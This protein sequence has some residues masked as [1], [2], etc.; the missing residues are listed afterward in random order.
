M[1]EFDITYYLIFLRESTVRIVIVRTSETFLRRY[2]YPIT[3]A[4]GLHAM[5]TPFL[6]PS[7]EAHE[8]Q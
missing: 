7:A 3:P 5:I 8:Y 1:N 6:H 2:Q 4:V